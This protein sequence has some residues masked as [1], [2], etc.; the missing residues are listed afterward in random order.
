MPGTSSSTR[1]GR[2]VGVIVAAL[3]VIIFALE[4]F[5]DPQVP[6]GYDGGG[7]LPGLAVAVVAVV[8]V[9]WT[10]RDALPPR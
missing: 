5:T 10:Y 6:Y 8:A 4:R 3:A 2:S 7:S 9:A 1:L